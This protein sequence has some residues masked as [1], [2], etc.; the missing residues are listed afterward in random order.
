MA[1]KKDAFLHYFQYFTVTKM[2]PNV[3]NPDS[4]I[5]HSLLPEINWNVLAFANLF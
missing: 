2:S 5:I 3:D 1:K 4:F